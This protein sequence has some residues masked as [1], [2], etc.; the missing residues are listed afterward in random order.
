MTTHGNMKIAFVGA[1]KLAKALIEGISTKSDSDGQATA[2][3]SASVKSS[4]SLDDLKAAWPIIKVD[5]DN[6]KTVEKAQIIFVGVKPKDLKGV[7][8]EIVEAVPSNAL[9]LS[10]AAG[11]EIAEFKKVMESRKD[12]RIGRLMANTACATG[13]GL[14]AIDSNIS[15]K[16]TDSEKSWLLKMGK[17]SV[18]DEKNFDAF[19]VLAAS[20]PAFMLDWIRA[21]FESAIKLGLD[22]QAATNICVGL[23]RGAA[24]QLDKNFDP[25]KHIAQIATPGG[26]TA[27][28]LK[29]LEEQKLKELVVLACE[30][31]LKKAQAWKS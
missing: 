9:I 2:Q 3:I 12:L 25:T 20:A 26:M 27:E 8:A 6:L 28:G 30:A 31:S 4:K 1:G 24:E 14:M 19:T 15:Q 22:S 16:M 23:L 13:E 5:T 18:I 7:L 17:L 11:M 29:V 10:L 21:L